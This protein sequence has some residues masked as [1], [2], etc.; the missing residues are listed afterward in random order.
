MNSISLP[1]DDQTEPLAPL[2]RPTVD[3][4]S[5]DD[6]AATML[7]A[8]RTATSRPKPLTTLTTRRPDSVGR[9]DAGAAA[10]VAAAK[11]SVRRR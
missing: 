3:E 1:D 11:A 7:R 6:E 5:R 4:T 2:P 8:T 9:T 10:A